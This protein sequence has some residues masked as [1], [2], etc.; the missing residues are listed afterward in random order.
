MVENWGGRAQAML[1]FDA[2]ASASADGKN[3]PNTKGWQMSATPELPRSRTRLWLLFPG[4][5]GSG[6]HPEQRHCG[7][8]TAN[9]R[10]ARGGSTGVVVP[11]ENQYARISN[12]PAFASIHPCGARVG[13]LHPITSSP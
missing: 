3:T 13:S 2:W 5:W 7:P 12:W 1:Q 10:L 4:F 6:M 9:G 8:G 11:K